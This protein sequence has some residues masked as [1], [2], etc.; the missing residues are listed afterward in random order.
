[1]NIVNPF[2]PLKTSGLV[3]L[4]VFFKRYQEKTV[5]RVK[6]PLK[7]FEFLLN[8]ICIVVVLKSYSVLLV[9]L[10]YI[11]TNKIKFKPNGHSQ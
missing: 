10:S 6:R 9:Y 5:K 4:D 1:M 8:P 3:L 11:Y 2:I 7:S